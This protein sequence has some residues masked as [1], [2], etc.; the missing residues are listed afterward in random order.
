MANDST[1]NYLYINKGDGTFED[2][3]YASGFALNEDGRETAS[4]GMAVGDYQNNGLARSLQSPIFRRLQGALS[5]RRRWQL[6]R[7]Q[8]RRRAS[9]RSTIPFLGWGDGFLDYDNDGWKDLMYRQRPR[10]SAGRQARLGH[11]LC[12]AAAAVS[13]PAG[14]GKFE[15]VPA[16]EGTGLALVIPARGAAFGDL[17][18]DGKIDVVI[19][20]MDSAAGAAAQREP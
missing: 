7:C 6:Y 18:N 8:L 11:D 14:Q 10:L 12:A 17:F 9:P 19:N 4:M 3:S 5:Q 2:D 1:P 16:V 15:V 13:Q 20:N